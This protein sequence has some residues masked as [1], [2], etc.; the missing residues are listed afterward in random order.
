MNTLINGKPLHFLW[1]AMTILFSSGC[2][3]SICDEIV[4]EVD[5]LEKEA[6]KNYNFAMKN[7]TTISKG[8]SYSVVYT[9]SE[10][11]ITEGYYRDM[12]VP[13]RIIS[14]NQKCF[15]AKRVA[16]AQELIAGK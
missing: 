7:R 2:S 11:E 4:L 6:E 3:N 14:N 5:L 12:R 10:E 9:R 13:A 1:L 8:T 16:E 15:D